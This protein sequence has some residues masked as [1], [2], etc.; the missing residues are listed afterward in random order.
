MH[1]EGGTMKYCPGCGGEFR[2]SAAR[3]A[4]CGCELIDEKKWNALQTERRME[5]DEVFVRVA[6][7][8]DRFEADV[9]RDALE[10]ERIPVLVRTFQDTSFDG[11]YVLQKGWA[12]L[13]VPA[14]FLERARA[15]IDAVRG[16]RP[17]P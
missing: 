13:E 3:C 2:D 15:V 6:E 16:A 11:M 7:A 8:G 12:L 4:E 10:K 5:A 1:A 17:S 14:T 9:F